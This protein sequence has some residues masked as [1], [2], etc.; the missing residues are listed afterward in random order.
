MKHIFIVLIIVLCCTNAMAQSSVKVWKE[1]LTLPTYLVEK[2]NLNPMF[3]DGEAYQGAQRHVYPYAESDILTDIR[4]NKTYKAAYLENKYIKVCVLPELGGK[5]FYAIDKTNSYDMFYH[6][7]VI[8]PSLVGMLGAWLSGGVEWDVPH[9]HRATS[10][11]PVDCVLKENAD[12]SKTIVVGEMELRHRMRW[13]VALTLY[14]DKSYIEVNVHIYNRTPLANSML[15]WANAGVHANADYQVI[16]PPDVEWGAQHSKVEFASWPIASGFYNGV[17][18]SNV[19]ISWWKNIT[20]YNSLFAWHSKATFIAGYDHGKHAGTLNVAEPRV[21]GGKKFWTLGSGPLGERWASQLTE[22]D[23]QYVELM[24]GAYSDNQPDYS[25]IQ[26][27]E[28]RHFKQYYYPIREIGGVKEANLQVAL[29]L[30]VVNENR[31]RLGLHSTSSLRDVKIIVRNRSDI[32]FEQVL[33]ISPDSPFVKEI[34]S[35]SIV[36]ADSLFAFLLSSDG[37]QIISYHLVKTS[38]TP[39]PEP[40]HPPPQPKDIS[41]VEELYLAGLRLDQFHNPAIDSY[42]YYEEA[43]KRDSGDSRVNTV[44]GMSYLKRGMFKEA[45]AKLRAALIRLTKGYTTPKEGEPYYYLGLA[46]KGQGKLDEAYDAFFKA[47]WYK[48]WYASASLSLAEL[49]S[50]KGDHISALM[51]I[52]QSLSANMHDTKAS[53][54]RAAILRHLGRR[55]EAEETSLRTLDEDPL[56]LWSLHEYGLAASTAGSVNESQAR[57]ND[58]KTKMRDDVQSYLELALDYGSAGLIDDAIHVLT[59]Y[60]K[61]NAEDSRFPM[62]YYYLGYFQ[63]KKGDVRNALRSYQQGSRM[64]TDYCF[65][66]RVESIDILR[67]AELSNPS[68]ARIKY[69]QGNLYCYLNRFDDA[70]RAWRRSIQLDNAFSITHRNLGWAYAWVKNDIPQ[71]IS[72]LEKAIA[73]DPKDPRLYLELDQL[74]ETTGV[75]AEKRLHTLEQNQATVSIRGDA[76]IREVILCTY[77]KMY[78]KAIRILSKNHF[79]L[80]EGGWDIHNHFVDAH[81]LRGVEKVH[82]GNFK[83]ALEDFETALEYPANL[84]VG[85]SYFSEKDD[86]AYYYL[87]TV[88]DILRDTAR[89][90]ESY[91]KALEGK[92]RSYDPE[93]F[94]YKGLSLLRLGQKEAGAKIFDGIIR[95][96]KERIESSAGMDYFAKFGIRRNHNVQMADAHYLLGLG[97]LGKGEKAKAKSEFQLSV[98]LDMNHLW[99]S[100]Q[101]E[102]NQ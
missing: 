26:P 91:R 19:N 89:A 40:V 10:F 5:I 80:W 95:H 97:Y 28:V 94:Y 30:E 69:Y 51:F 57:L 79:Y 93:M 62:L 46:L 37:K 16:F 22:T 86:Q 13:T 99:A 36:K 20:M 14:P 33:D 102:W 65:P 4:Q 3:Y 56:N 88:Y 47:T 25:W 87:G 78:D 84:E 74:C 29:N 7:H 72:C 64:P 90:R 100:R 61:S 9:H 70:M 73:C 8:R 66:F 92:Q 2:P 71:A 54:L 67:R 53:S 68:D 48:S 81:V 24:V 15:Y 60:I 44:L 27:G 41:T 77:L 32:C 38:G 23:G 31:I 98:G 58:L 18:Y 1:P 101:L 42:P 35:P 17:D 43:L 6:Q 50:V 75:S 96:A 83:E 52:D 49:A 12:G 59:S 85:K 82:K 63:E 11:M 34:T 45:E 76:L 39:M 55:K 21:V